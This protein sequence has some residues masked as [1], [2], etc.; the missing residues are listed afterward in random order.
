[1]HSKSTGYALLAPAVLL[2]AGI[3]LIPVLATIWLSFRR[4]LP[5]FGISEFVAFGNYRVLAQDPRFWSAVGHTVYFVIVSVSFEVV[6]G[7]S[8]ALLLNREF[9]GR[10]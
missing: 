8:I 6:L 1:M 9:P 2:S 10:A 7:T 3:T 5:I 4:E